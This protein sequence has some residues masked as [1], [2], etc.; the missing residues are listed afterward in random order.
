M[1]LE[2]VHPEDRKHVRQAFDHPVSIKSKYE[3]TYR[4]VGPDGEIKYI[5]ALSHLVFQESAKPKNTS[6]R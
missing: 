3:N 1:F 6:A 2:V 4:I 5:R